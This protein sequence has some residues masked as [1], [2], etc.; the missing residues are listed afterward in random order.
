MTD[1]K[2]YKSILIKLLAIAIVILLLYWTVGEQGSKIIPTLKE[3]DTYYLGLS[4]GLFG[5]ALI[6][7]YFRWL[8]LLRVQDINL[9]AKE[10]FQLQLS[11]YFFN[12]T[13]PGAVTGDLIK[14]GTVMRRDPDKQ[15]AA[16]MSI[17]MDRLIGLIA[18]LI[19]VLAMTIPALDFVMKDSSSEIRLATLIVA[20]GALCGLFGVFLWA[21]RTK[22]AQ[23]KIF[24]KLIDWIQKKS[25]RL[26]LAF[27]EIITSIEAYSD[28]KK[29]CS[30]LLLLSIII[31][32]LL[33]LSFYFIGLSL[34]LEISPIL[35]ILSIQ[36]SNALAAVF[37]LP[38]GLGLRDSIGKSFLLAAGCP[39]AQAAVAPLL[40]SGVTLGWGLVGAIIF[41]HWRMTIKKEPQE[42]TMVELKNL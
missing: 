27:K 42:E 18:L 12:T 38:G 40:Y 14:I 21:I 26:Y 33:G 13:T 22:L 2:K 41:V 29:T 35:F 39:A 6:M 20:G 30:A 9:T 34:G 25:E 23:I 16:V 36:V 1:G 8:T 31:H 11:G 5:L 10:T 28:Q 24:R 19:F 17:F 3:A 15:I 4:A 7:Q 37:P 32:A